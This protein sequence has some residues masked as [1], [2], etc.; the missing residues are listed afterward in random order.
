VLTKL[1][2]SH[3]KLKASYLK[4]YSKLP[5][6]LLVNHDACAT[7]STFFEAFMTVGKAPTAFVL[8]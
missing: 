1:T 8:P 7:N 4:K 3:E 6:P 5:S 2:E